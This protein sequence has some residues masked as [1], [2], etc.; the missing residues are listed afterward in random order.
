MH[1]WSIKKELFIHLLASF[2]FFLPFVLLHRLGGMNLV[3]FVT[4]ILIGVFLPDI[5]HLIYTLFLKPKEITSQRIYTKISGRNFLSAVSLL[6]TTRDERKNLIFHNMFFQCLFVVFAFLIV[7]SNSS[8]LGRGLVV[9]FLLSLVVDQCVDLY[10]KVPLTRWIRG[11][12]VTLTFQQFYLY[13][14]VQALLICV[15]GYLF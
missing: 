14:T 9:S 15:L 4:G 7:S 5:D 10:T 8:L 6:F 13:V 1:L 3:L 2:V 11:L 12:P